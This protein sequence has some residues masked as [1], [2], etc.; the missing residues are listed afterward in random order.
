ML[1]RGRCSHHRIPHPSTCVFS[2]L[3]HQ[4]RHYGILEL[5]EKY[6]PQ[7]RK[8]Q[9]LNKH[10]ATPLERKIYA[11]A[12]RVAKSPKFSQEMI[13]SQK[14]EIV[15]T[16]LKTKPN[17]EKIVSEHYNWNPYNVSGQKKTRMPDGLPEIPEEYRQGGF[18]LQQMA[19]KD[20]TDIYKMF[21]NNEVIKH[22]V[23]GVDMRVDELGHLLTNP[24]K[25][26][27]Y[28]NHNIAQG[29]D[30]NVMERMMSQFSD[31]VV[32]TWHGPRPIEMQ[33]ERTP[34]MTM[35]E[36]EEGFV[37]YFFC[38]LFICVFFCHFYF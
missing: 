36:T 35:Q 1:T 27:G 33:Q 31:D 28:R 25:E 23:G 10:D 21:P 26:L 13:V 34:P 3:H 32:E 7:F 24:L 29:R 19:R 37:F 14:N 8:V 6:G 17:M 2:S 5:Q 4:Y 38:C 16:E 12:N 18:G 11:F 9:K 15:T 22:I 20:T 30:Y